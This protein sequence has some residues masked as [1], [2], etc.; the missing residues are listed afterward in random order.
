MAT[1][2]QKADHVRAALEKKKH[3]DH[4]CHW[5][6]CDQQVAPAAWGCRVHWYMLPVRLRNKIWAAYRAGQEV[7]RTPSREY[8]KVAREVRNWIVDN[9]GD[10]K[11]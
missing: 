9:Y 1:I 3:R 7:N 8:V 6:G 10:G 5:P 2:K 11:E 4:H